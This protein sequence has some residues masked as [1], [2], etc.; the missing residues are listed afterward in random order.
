MGL[1]RGLNARGPAPAGGCGRCQSG[2][3]RAM[4]VRSLRNLQRALW[5]AFELAIQCVGRTSQTYGV[6]F[7]IGR[8]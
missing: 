8:D 4:L 3:Y 1:G 7:D 6:D 2:N 5:D